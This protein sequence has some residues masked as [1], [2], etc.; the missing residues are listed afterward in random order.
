MAFLQMWS[1][2]V[3]T[4]PNL[5]A[6]LAQKY[7]KRAYRDICDSRSWSF[8]Q[9]SGYVSAPNLISDGTVTVVL[10]SDQVIVDAL[11]A[12]AI[13]AVYNDP[14]S[15]LL[16]RQFRL[17]LGP[18]Y[19][20][21]TWDFATR[22]LTLDDVYQGASATAQAYQIYQALYP[23]PVPTF[24]R[25]LSIADPN[26]AYPF[27]RVHVPK[28]LLDRRDP[29]RSAQGQPYF[30]I[31]YGAAADGSPLFEFWPHPIAPETF[32]LTYLVYST[33]L[34]SPTDTVPDVIPESLIISRAVLRYAIPW[35]MANQGRFPQLKGINWA[36]LIA[37]H[38]ESYERD[39]ARTKQSDDGRKLATRILRA[40]QGLG[41]PI[42]ANFAQSH[43]GWS[44]GAWSGSN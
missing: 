19:G 15:P 41:P 7:V 33:V 6:F 31:D 9:Q 21:T 10:G 13:D 12:S 40:H 43:G 22:T 28:A 24:Q 20:M 36:Q 27:T 14:M 26:N 8:K 5:S 16:N 25:F 18:L 29:Q 1:E 23:A 44:S 30:C 38:K 3:G 39:L 2:I 37:L 42:D 35:A 34:E 32:T 11:A 4:I 17:P